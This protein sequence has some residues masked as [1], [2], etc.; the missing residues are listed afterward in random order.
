MKYNKGGDPPSMAALFLVVY[1][2]FRQGINCR[3]MLN[4]TELRTFDRLKA[5]QKHLETYGLVESIGKDR[6]NFQIVS[7]L[8]VNEKVAELKEMVQ[9]LSVEELKRVM[10]LRVYRTPRQNYP[11]Y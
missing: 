1:A 3:S 5:G 10:K 11:A 7:V 9:T 8:P 2:G 4:G 6:N